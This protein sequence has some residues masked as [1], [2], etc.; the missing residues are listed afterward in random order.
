[1]GEVC[2]LVELVSLQESSKEA[3]R[4]HNSTGVLGYRSMTEPRLEDD[5]YET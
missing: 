5:V 3:E 1:M 4:L 2:T